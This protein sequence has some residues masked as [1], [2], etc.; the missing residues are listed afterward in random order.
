MSAEL[1]SPVAL[2]DIHAGNRI[3]MSPM[4]RRRADADGTP[5]ELMRTYYAQRASAGLIVTGSVHTSLAGKSQP[6]SP[7]LVTDRDVAGWARITEA[8]HER[9]GRIVVQLMHAGLAAHPSV[10]GGR[11]PLAPSAIVP[12]DT[13]VLDGK[14]VEHPEPR[15]MTTGEIDG[16]VEEFARAAR[17]AAAAGFD[18]VEIHGGNGYLVHQFLASG[19]N[20]RDDAYG[21]PAENRIRF[22][23]RVVEAVSAA[24]GASRTGLRVSPGFSAN[25][26]A[27]QDAAEVYP[28]LLSHPSVRRLAYVHTI[29]G[30]DQ[31][32]L[33]WL[34]THKAGAWIHN[35][36]TD[37]TWSAG[38][39]VAR[40]GEL[41]T[42]GCDALSLGRLFVS[43][44]DLPERLALGAPLTAPDPSRFYGGDGEGYTD[45]GPWT[46][47]IGGPIHV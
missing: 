28:A 26:L 3:V 23:V 16:V 30:S 11:T 47:R 27:E 7:H 9:G 36:G 25:R 14:I 15:A 22:A 8:V 21:G 5:N 29:T 33:D 19:T 41:L 40:L 32:V 42:S 17:L 20:L 4:G 2:G 43:N 37:L 13:A 35:M 18:G 10:N 34:R 44:P 45:Y 46:T 31:G 12:R 38:E 39:L 6:G 24:V 1:F